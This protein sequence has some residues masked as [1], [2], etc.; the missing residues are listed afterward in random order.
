MTT[1]QIV[2]TF[3]AHYGYKVAKGE[4]EHLGSLEA[5]MP[6]LLL[7]I[8]Q[9]LFQHQIAPLSEHR[10]LKHLATLWRT[11]YDKFNGRLFAAF[12]EDGQEAVVDWM[13]EFS[14]EMRNELVMLKIAAA[15]AVP[16]DDT[17][18][19]MTIGSSWVILTLCY[20]ARTIYKRFYQELRPNSKVRRLSGRNNQLSPERTPEIDAM[21][22]AM[23][24]W[25]DVY[26]VENGLKRHISKT[27]KIDT[28]TNAII[29]KCVGWLETEKN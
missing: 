1:R 4:A 27:P 29:H 8:A 19:R 24:E 22:H 23:E 17:D 3:M 28:I 15:E 10:R 20:I 26:L 11:N 7:D 2:E 21:T 25:P 12:D 9:D 5:V 6:W 18:K 16:F 14:S 13:D